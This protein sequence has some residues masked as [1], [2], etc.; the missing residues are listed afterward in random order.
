MEFDFDGFTTIQGRNYIGKS[1]T[2]RAINAALT[3]QQGTNFIRWGQKFCEVR[4]KTEVIDIL[5]HK[6]KGN[7]FYKINNEDPYTKVGSLPPPQPILDAGFGEIS[8]AGEKVN[9]LYS[10][11]F[12]PLFLI[13]RKDSKSAD[14]LISIYGLDKLYKAID[15]CA[16]DQ[17]KNTDVLKL[18]KVDLEQATESL[19][20]FAEFDKVKEALTNIETLKTNLSNKQNDI[21]RLKTWLEQASNLSVSIKKIKPARS[22]LVPSYD[23]IDKLIVEQTTL[24]K[25]QNSI[26]ILKNTVIKLRPV[27]NINIPKNEVLESKISEFNEL[28]KTQDKYESLSKSVKLFKQSKSI[29]IPDVSDSKI[30][31]IDGLKNIYKR[32]TVLA[33]EVK[34]LRTNVASTDKE[35]EK[36]TI[37]LSTYNACPVCGNKLNL[38]E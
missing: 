35:L 9:L 36:V 8:V 21:S 12:H 13:D 20:K 26:D 38:K 19:N 17:R 18:R 4:L 24:K 6:E 28:N 37:D 2:L 3:N 14:L 33:T 23:K 27:K 29:K 31:E 5:W 16:K 25:Y 1:A 7:N 10:E 30:K 34:T 22:I 11:Q 15:L 32:L